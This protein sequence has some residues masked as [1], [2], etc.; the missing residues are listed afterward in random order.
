M[1]VLLSV[2]PAYIWVML[3]LMFNAVCTIAYWGVELWPFIQSFKT[4]KLPKQRDVSNL[5]W[6]EALI[7]MVQ[8]I[9]E[10][11]N[12]IIQLLVRSRKAMPFVVDFSITMFLMGALGL[13]GNMGA[14]LSLFMSNVI[15]FILVI[16]IKNLGVEDAE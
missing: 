14:S 7:S 13:S 3:F 1:D 9:I 8:Q 10:S 4:I 6:V 5:N 12:F 2:I 16:A 15:S 11:G